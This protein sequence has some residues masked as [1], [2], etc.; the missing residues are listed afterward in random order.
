MIPNGFGLISE[1][2]KRRSPKV[3]VEQWTLGVQAVTFVHFANVNI[4]S[5]STVNNG[6]H[7]RSILE[8]IC[9]LQIIC[10]T[11]QLLKST[12][13]PKQPNAIGFARQSKNRT[14]LLLVRPSSMNLLVRNINLQVR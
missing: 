3:N 6:D 10:G 12:I 11:V 7:L 1:Q 14:V 5:D 13:E 9:G 8:I 2:L 4:Y